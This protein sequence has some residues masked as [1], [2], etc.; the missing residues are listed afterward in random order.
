MVL[1]QCVPGEL[2]GGLLTTMRAP[3]GTTKTH[4]AKIAY[5]NHK[6]SVNNPYSQFRD[7]YTLDQ[8]ASS[9]P[10]YEP[11]TKLQCCPTSRF[12]PGES[13]ASHADSRS[14]SDFFLRLLL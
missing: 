2:Q 8:I 6:N 14:C 1:G 7:E 3:P 11:L 12:W 10:I 4:F 13:V 5:K 9:R